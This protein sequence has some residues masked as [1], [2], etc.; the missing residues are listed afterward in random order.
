VYIGRSLPRSED[1]RFLTG[2]S[3]FVDDLRFEDLLHAVFVRSP[4]AHAEVRSV[5]PE[6]ARSRSRVVGVFTAADFAGSVGR[7]P[8]N[9]AEGAE[10]VDVPHP[11][12]ASDRV[13]YVGEPVA[14]VVATD[15]AAAADAAE[16]VV[17]DY[18]ELPS[19]TVLH[20]AAPD[21][22][23]MRWSHS[24]GLVDEAFAA[25][26][27]VVR[28]R[29]RM[30]R[31]IAAPLEPRGA[32]ASYDEDDDLMT[33]WVSAQDPY[34]Q[35]SSLSDL[36]RRERDRLRVVVPD[37]GGAFGSKG[38]PAPE[39]AVVALC[40]LGLGRP[41][42]WIETRTENSLAAYQGRG[43][44]AH[45]ELALDGD[46]RM[47]AL[48]ARFVYDLGAYLYPTTPVPPLTAAR[49]CVGCYRIPAA[50]VE[51]V[52]VCTSKVPTGPYRGAGRPEAAF[53]IERLVDLAA[54]Q[55]G[56]DRI[57][58]RRRNLI[59]DFPHRTPLGFTYDSGDYEAALDRVLALPGPVESSSDALFGSGVALYV[60]RVGPGWESAQVTINQDGRVVCRMGSTPHGQGHETTFAQIAAHELRVEP[61]VVEVWYGDS[62]EIPE[63]TGTFASRS[64]TVGGSALL[65]ACREAQARLEGG[66]S[67]PVEASA[68]FELA[69]PVFS[70]GAYAAMVEIDPETGAVR[71]LQI[72]AIDDCGTVVN[73]LL[74]HGQVVGATVQALGECLLEQVGY[75]ETGQPVAVNFYDYRLPKALDVPPIDGELMETPSPLNPL[76]AKGIGEAGSI[77]TTAA[78]ANAVCD[79]LAPVGIRHL[80]P[81]FTPARVWEAM[82]RASARTRRIEP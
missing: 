24:E 28:Q 51:I 27:H 46:G 5:E 73:P 67:Y 19:G 42:K 31:L 65:L 13:R 71:V 2:T 11:V 20:S 76:G 79:A 10:I 80:D 48:R 59:R 18:E 60:E 55:I 69:A 40:S 63:G 12:L 41:V 66:A 1:V 77:G 25:A 15:R 57:Q 44:D 30:P 33:I 21:N 8:I 37:V 53:M 54:A 23:I 26:E 70:Y 39:T 68:T 82:E 72:A 45:A 32:V 38:V 58:L 64:V 16:S 22:V 47:L 14:V 17:V 50:S 74:A 75:D 35:R 43:M 36:L 4:L 7:F 34:R 61:D 56:A 6:A 78:V 81:P 3:R 29:L 52:G 9:P 62:A 49:L